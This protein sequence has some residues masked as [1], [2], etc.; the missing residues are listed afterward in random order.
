MRLVEQLAPPEK[1]GIVGRRRN[2]NPLTHRGADVGCDGS[3]A[4]RDQR[5][6]RR[7][8]QLQ[9]EPV[10]VEEGEESVAEPEPVAPEESFLADP[11]STEKRRGEFIE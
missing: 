2:G 11:R 9:N 1:I 7:F 8:G 4:T 10:T 3:L 5:G 6:S